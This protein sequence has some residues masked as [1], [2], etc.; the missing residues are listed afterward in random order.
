MDSVSSVGEGR[1]GELTGEVIVGDD[2][3]AAVTKAMAE[4]QEEFVEAE[5]AV[6][7]AALSAWWR[8]VKH[9]DCSY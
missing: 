7:A 8:V 1:L 9:L 2:V 6:A 4:V 5:R 3:T